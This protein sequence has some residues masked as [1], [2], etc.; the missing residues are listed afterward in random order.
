M[1][2]SQLLLQFSETCRSLMIRVFSGRLYSAGS[3]D[4]LLL[5]SLNFFRVHTVECCSLTLACNLRTVLLELNRREKYNRCR[6]CQFGF[7]F[8][9]TLSLKYEAES[10]T[11]NFWW[12][13]VVARSSTLSINFW[14]RDPNSRTWY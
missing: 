6:G 3:R 12:S 5:T 2:Q 7:P 14:I 8:W 10:G 9:L 1:K 13:R 11:M 4:H